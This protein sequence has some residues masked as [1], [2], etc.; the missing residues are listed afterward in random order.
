MK[1]KTTS[2]TILII[3]SGIIL[4]TYCKKKEEEAPLPP[5]NFLNQPMSGKVNG[6]EWVLGAGRSI[7]TNPYYK[8]FFSDS[9]NTTN[10][11]CNQ[12]GFGKRAIIIAIP[13]IEQKIYGITYPGTSALQ[14]LIVKE[15]G[16][17]YYVNGASGALEVLSIDNEKITG[18]IDAKLNDS[19]YVNGNFTIQLCY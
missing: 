16:N 8:F 4:L 1:L 3:L 10:D 13:K 18:R 14:F 2:L 17:S 19:N 6:Q 12:T 11:L 7:Y 15:D 9:V 5:H